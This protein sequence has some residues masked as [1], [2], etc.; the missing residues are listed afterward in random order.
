MRKG[1]TDCLLIPG[2]LCDERLWAA[3]TQALSDIACC[4]TVDLTADESIYEMADGILSQAPEQFALAG[5]SMGG[6]V[7]LEILARAPRRVLQ[8][9]LLSTNAA[10]ILPQV[11]LH[12]EES[13]KRLEGGGLVEYLV[14]AFPKYVAPERI[15]DL[16]LWE[17][18]SDMGGDL[19]AA[20]AIRQMRALLG[21]RGFEGDLGAILCPTL[22]ICGERDERT[23]VSAH[24][25]MATRIPG[26][27]LKVIEG[28]AH[29]TPLEKP[30]AVAWM[31]REWMN[32]I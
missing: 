27:Q 31:L 22:L 5:F 20:V 19:G 3:Q 13:I 6:C 10:G 17:I 7:A 12:Y 16:Q 21:Y 23:P 29:F 15:H 18:F 14:E 24:Q 32:R 4:R 26:A 28:A 1:V 2:L 8:L 9:A 30:A 11:R 25:V